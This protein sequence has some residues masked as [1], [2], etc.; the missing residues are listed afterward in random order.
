MPRKHYTNGFQTIL[1]FWAIL[2]GFY[3]FR[4]RG[5]ARQSFVEAAW[6]AVENISIIFW[7]VAVAAQFDEK[8]TFGEVG[9]APQVQRIRFPSDAGM[10]AAIRA[11]AGSH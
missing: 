1:A 8:A 6:R 3:G 9:A 4:W 10:T 7:N 5:N 2:A 11:V